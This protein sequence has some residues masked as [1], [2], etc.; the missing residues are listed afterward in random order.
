MKLTG[1]T[2]LIT[3]GTSGIGLEFAKELLKRENTVIITGRNKT[4]LDT[5]KKLLPKAHVIQNDVGQ[6]KEI[7]TLF[8]KVTKEFPD[9]NIVINNAGIMKG[10]NFHDERTSLEDLTSEIDI[11]LKGPIR[12]TKIFLPHLKKKTNAAIVN[13]S[14]GL[15]FV[16][17]PISPVYCSTKAALHSFTLSMRA[18]L[19]NT[20][21]KVFEVAPP[22]T[23]TDLMG[24][25][26]SDHLKGV[27]IMSVE[28]MVRISLNGMQND[29]YEIRPGQSNQLNF[30]NRIAPNFILKQ[31]SKS[32]DL[33]LE[34]I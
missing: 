12:M 24:N 26:N 21:I 31:L 1:N 17:L 7:Q 16:P 30:M 19:K 29:K 14:S 11:N 27:P 18:Q 23:K 22:A 6:L 5:A 2:V 13:V 15:A 9:L 4:K 34:E 8:D 32:V 33:M 28:D 25:F 3:G 20:N 10:I